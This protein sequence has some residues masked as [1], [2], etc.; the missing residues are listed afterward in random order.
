MPSVTEG[1]NMMLISAVKSMA[2]ASF[3]LLLAQCHQ[4][5]KGCSSWDKEY[6]WN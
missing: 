4:K 5:V 1:E 6:D 3:C 2:K